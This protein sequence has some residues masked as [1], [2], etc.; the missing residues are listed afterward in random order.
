MQQPIKR[1]QGTNVPEIQPGAMVVHD[2]HDDTVLGSV[3]RVVVD[4]NTQELT[5]I[6]VR[7]GRADY[8]L[9]VPADF[10]EVDEPGR[11]RIRDDARL[12]DLERLAIESGRTPPTG[13][14]IKE[15]EHTAPAPQPEEV[16]GNTPIM[17]SNWDGP[18][19]G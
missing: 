17:P 8:L 12:E 11:V 5:E 18:S 16:I 13:T 7:P 1:D 10:L 3:E 19:T 6:H 9:K 4:P 14:H 2:G 15:V